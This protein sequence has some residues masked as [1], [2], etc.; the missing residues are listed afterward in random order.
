VGKYEP[1]AEHLRHEPND[2]WT[3]AF[4]EVERILGFPLP[5][6]ARAYRPW[7]GNQRGAG[8]SQ[9]K[10]WQDAGWQVLKVDLAA[11]TVEFGRAVQLSKLPSDPD[12]EGRLFEQAGEILGT[13]DR[14]SIVREALHGLIQREAARRLAR[15]G[16][17]MPDLQ[18]PPRR[19]FGA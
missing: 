7:W 4:A 6:S 9:A 2:S 19:R 3:A 15:L 13:N 17:S 14:G 5:P 10:G 8:H 12:M 18:A 16:G 1:L 11:E